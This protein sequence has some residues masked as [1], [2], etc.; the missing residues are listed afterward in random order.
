M[1]HHT[2]VWK[3]R[4]FG[5]RGNDGIL[6]KII[7]YVLLIGIS[8]IFLFPLLSMLSMSFMTLE[9]LIDSSIS[10]VPRNLTG[11]NYVIAFAQLNFSKALYK[12]F[13]I[14]VLPTIAAIASSSLIGYGLAKFQFPGKKLIL[15]LMLALFLIPTILTYIPT[16]VLY[17]DLKLFGINLNL[18]GSLRAFVVPAIFGFGLRQTIFILIF[19]Q[20]FRII[21]HDLYEAAEVDGSGVL[22]TFIKIAIPLAGPAFLICGLYAFVWYWN[23]TTLARAYFG[24]THT[25]LLMSLESY[26]STYRS[27]FAQGRMTMDSVSEVYNLGVQYSM[28][29]IAIAPLIIIYLFVQKGFVE[30]IDKSGIAGN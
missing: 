28:T 20:F 30:G 15:G 26:I 2:L 1:R 14:S 22:G 25:S 23:E 4:I 19:Y 16:T 29:L 3:R 21:P 18:M 10:W 13:L 8:F 11:R 24:Q 5:R 27:L 17:Q 9:D 6:F 12:S 7:L